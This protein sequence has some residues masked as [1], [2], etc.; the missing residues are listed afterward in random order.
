MAIDEF[1]QMPAA[2]HAALGI[3]GNQVDHASS[4]RTRSASSSISVPLIP[5][6]PEGADQAAGAA[7][8]NQVGFDAGGVECLDDANVGKAARR[9]LPST[10]ASC[11]CA[12]AP[13]SAESLMGSWLRQAPGAASASEQLATIGKR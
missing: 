6:R 4:S 3:A 8:D 9:A 10:T 1:L 5:G 7:A 11:R 12:H 2:N 13:A